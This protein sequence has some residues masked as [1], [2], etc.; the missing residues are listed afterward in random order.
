MSN[1]ELTKMS[2]KG[3]IVIPRQVRK[4]LELKEGETFAVVGKSDTIILKKIEIP[5]QKEV[6]E[7]L[8]KWGVK[9]A[10]E[11]GLK[12]SDIQGMIKRTRGL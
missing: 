9:F 12:E 7:K 5:S 1:T 4:E 2:S 6:F 11:K 8:H 3:Q 10:K